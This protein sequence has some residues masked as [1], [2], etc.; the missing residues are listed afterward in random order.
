[1]KDGKNYD[2]PEKGITNEAVGAYAVKCRISHT[3]AK[4]RLEE[5]YK[6]EVESTKAKEIAL[7][8]I[9][10]IRLLTPQIAG[11]VQREKD[12][13]HK[14]NR[15]E[16]KVN[17]LEFSVKDM[18]EEMENQ[19]LT[20]KKAL[21]TLIELQARNKPPKGFWNRIKWIFKKN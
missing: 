13:M 17:S 16:S 18:K 8:C 15:I 1:M 19:K 5:N 4:E 14:I 9:K 12:W 6:K 2:D 7:K 3:E 10:A 20:F 21:V 11:V